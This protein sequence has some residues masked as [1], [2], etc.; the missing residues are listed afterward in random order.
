VNTPTPAFEAA[1]TNSG[2][3]T[4]PIPAEISGEQEPCASILYNRFE[5]FATNNCLFFASSSLALSAD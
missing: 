1:A 3:G 4:K 5:Q 2:S